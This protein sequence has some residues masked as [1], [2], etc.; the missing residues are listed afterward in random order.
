MSLNTAAKAEIIKTYQ[1]AKNDTGSS[2]VQIA[3]LSARI[4]Y[5]TEH[6]KVHS[7]DVHTRFGLTKL[8]SKRRRLLNYLKKSDLKLYRDVIAKLNIRG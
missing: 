2:E 5:L 6:L 7:H 8:V 4:E 3:L 1:K